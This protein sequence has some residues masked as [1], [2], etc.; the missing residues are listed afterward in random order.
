MFT[1]SDFINEKWQNV[2]LDVKEFIL[3][4]LRKNPT[5]RPTLKEMLNSK[6]LTKI[7]TE[8]AD[9]ET[10]RKALERLLMFKTYEG[11]KE[12]LMKYIA[13]HADLQEE[14]RKLTRVFKDIDTAN[15]QVLT[16]DELKKGNVFGV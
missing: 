8:K 3:D 4:M 10:V 13:Y 12:A 14:Q 5:E 15:D 11:S 2:S 6:W 1:I 16:Y 9:P 7:E